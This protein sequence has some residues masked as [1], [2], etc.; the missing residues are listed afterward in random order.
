MATTDRT[1]KMTKLI[2]ESANGIEDAV[3]AALTTSG[4][5]VHGQSWAE[6]HACGSGWRMVAAWNC[7]RSRWRS[8]SKS[9]G[10]GCC[11]GLGGVGR[12]P[13]PPDGARRPWRRRRSRTVHGGYRSAD[14]NE[15][16]A[17][18]RCLRTLWRS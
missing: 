3:R 2:G 14:P 15:R 8:R 17:A 13:A 18:R 7:G 10:S 16:T 12:V 6:L 4:E 1:Y 5:K 11:A 9:T